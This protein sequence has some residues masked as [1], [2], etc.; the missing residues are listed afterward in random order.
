MRAGLVYVVD[1]DTLV[2]NSLARL[3]RSADFE[4]VTF[5]SPEEFLQRYD[6]HLPGC[7]VLDLHLGPNNG[8]DIYRSY[9]T[10]NHVRPTVFI[11][12]DS[13]V[14]T[15]VRAMK[16][17]AV[18]FLM[19]PVRAEALIAAVSQAI[20][21]DYR[22]RQ[23]NAQRAWLESK[24]SRLT[25]REHQVLEGVIGG[26]LNKQIAVQMNIAEKTIKV[27]RH[28][29]MAKMEVRS[30]AELVSLLNIANRSALSSFDITYDPTCHFLDERLADAFAY[31]KGRCRDGAGMPE[32]DDILVGDMARFSE[33]V[34]IVKVR[35]DEAGTISYFVRHAG[36]E[37]ERV[38]GRLSGKALLDVVPEDQ[39]MRWR[40]P[41]DHVRETKRPL[42]SFGRM[43]FPGKTWL[44]SENFYA[45]LGNGA[46]VT[47]VFTAFV[48]TSILEPE[49]HA[50]RGA[51]SVAPL[52]RMPGTV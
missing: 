11:T 3:L 31:W 10:S 44:N 24:I 40:R 52:P 37:V 13:D 36:T 43:A 19:K 25:P 9:S 28:R 34:G 47:G 14:A 2:L 1:D 45:P 42:R 12:G 50:A 15:G 22:I 38:L 41:F 51:T 39:L 49:L 32:P 6:E 21:E 48:A 18:D 33:H 30:V 46:E 27:H 23:A 35:T 17:G 4:V 26:L 8:L 29:V 16:S 7:V 20:D 5:S